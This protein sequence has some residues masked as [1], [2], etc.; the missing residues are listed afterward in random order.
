MKRATVFILAVTILLAGVHYSRAVSKPVIAVEIFGIEFCPQSVCGA[1]DFGG[2]FEGHI[3]ARNFVVGD[4]EVS[5]THDPLPSPN[6][7]AAITGG[8]WLLVSRQGRFSGDIV[9][10]T[11]LNN[12]DNTYTVDALLELK[13]GGTGDLIFVG[14]LNH[15]TVVP[16]ITGS[17]SQ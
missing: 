7:T 2:A 13:Q 3:G 5:V 16:T 10:G 14:K 1:A 11:L 6:E 9:E 17:L 15:N 12:G 8:S 4:F